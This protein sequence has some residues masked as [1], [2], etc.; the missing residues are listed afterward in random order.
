MDLQDVECLP[1]QS[2]LHTAFSNKN[3]VKVKASGSPQALRL[4]LVVKNSTLPIQYVYS[5]KSFCVS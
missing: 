5:I 2:G 1:Y 4:W 3:V